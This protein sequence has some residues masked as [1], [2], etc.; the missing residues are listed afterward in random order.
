MCIHHSMVFS[1]FR[2][3]QTPPEPIQNF[4]ILTEKETLYH[5]LLPTQSILTCFLWT[6][7]FQTFQILETI[8]NTILCDW[9]LS[10]STCSGFIDAAARIG[11]SFL[12]MQ[13][14]YSILFTHSSA[15]GHLHCFH[16]D[17]YEECCCEHRVY[18]FVHT[19][20]VSWV[21]TW[22]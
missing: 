6:G 3:V 20:F 13:C 5:L 8:Q 15:D 4:F 12:F 16:F 2:V 18:I 21:Y 10:L 11:I 19:D 14:I 7:L 9:L 1:I 22:K 17:Q